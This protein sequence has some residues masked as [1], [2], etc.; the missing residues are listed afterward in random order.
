MKTCCKCKN[1]KLESEF[2][3]NKST[4]DGLQ[5]YCRECKKQIAKNWYNG[6]GRQTHLASVKKIIF[7][8]EK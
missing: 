6:A 2:C 5:K 8:T 7:D 1:R 3:K 4:A